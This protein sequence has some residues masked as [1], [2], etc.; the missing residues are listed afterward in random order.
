MTVEVGR[1]FPLYAGSSSQCILA[2][3][4]QRDREEVLSGDL[5]ALTGNTIVDP[6]RLRVVLADIR[7]T[8]HAFS[9]GE[10]QPGSAS[11]AAPV[12]DFSGA[13]VGSLSVCGPAE[14]VDEAAG[15]RYAPLVRAAAEQ[16][17][18][19]LGWSGGLPDP[20]AHARHA[21]EARA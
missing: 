17:S 8:G 6:D 15:E 19:A 11:V 21:V 2:F 20:D 13:V 7:A 3:L 4:P 14:R 5:E 12:F 18:R 10:R 16:V 9:R 1:R